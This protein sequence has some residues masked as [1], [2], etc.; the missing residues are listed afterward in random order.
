MRGL[1]HRVN[2]SVLMQMMGAAII[3]LLR[4]EF[5]TDDATPVAS[6]YAGE[7]G[8]LTVVQTDGTLAVA[9]GV[10]SYTA[11]TTPTDGD[12]GFVAATGLARTAGRGLYFKLTP[13]TLN[14]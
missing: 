2:G 9:S 5:S 14:T 11:Q 6:P 4:V 13:T 3:Y 12:E 7:V 8:S 1:A 10:L